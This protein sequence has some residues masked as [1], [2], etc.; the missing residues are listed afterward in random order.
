MDTRLVCGLYQVRPLLRPPMHEP[1]LDL[2]K[3]E[4]SRQKEVVRVFYK[5]MW[6]HA[7]T[8][9]VPQIFHPD[10][11]FRGSLGP[12]L[13]GHEQF[14]GYV[15]FVTEAL[16]ATRLTSLPSGRMATMSRKAGR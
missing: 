2:A 3:A 6:D 15:R 5:E 12:E 7:D 16:T 9:L 8:S 10:F 1:T 14:I 11:T 4:W 13:V